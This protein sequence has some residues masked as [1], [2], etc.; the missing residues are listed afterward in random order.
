MQQNI[1]QMAAEEGIDFQ[2]QKPTLA[3]ASMRIASFTLRKA[4]AWA[5][6]PRKPFSRLHD[7]RFSD[8]RTRS[9]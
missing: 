8:W 6:R 1:A 9:G 3:I 2:W 7:R 5:I 4:K